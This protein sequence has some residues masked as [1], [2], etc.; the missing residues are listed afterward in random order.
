MEQFVSL[1]LVASDKTG[2]IMLMSIFHMC[3]PLKLSVT[4]HIGKVWS[5]PQDWNR[6]ESKI[7][8]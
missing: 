3:A 8:Q 4:V 1:K 6:F 7:G 2:P 5:G